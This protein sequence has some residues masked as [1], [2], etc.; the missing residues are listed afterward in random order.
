[1]L[2]NNTIKI[3]NP[4]TRDELVRDDDKLIDSNGNI[5]PIIK[6]VP[7]ISQLNN[8][9][10]NFGMQWNKFDK[11][12]L[13]RETEGLLLSQLR[14]FAESGWDPSELDG[15]NILEVGSGAGRFTKVVLERTKA[16]LFSVDYSD[17][18]TANYSNNGVKYADRLNLY[19]A[20]IYEMP[21]NDNVF[22]KVFCF[23]VLQHT[24]NFQLSIKALL[25]KV[26]IGGEVVVDFYPVKGWWTKIHAKYLFRPLTKKINH[27]KLLKI[28]ENNVGWLIYISK[29]LNKFGLSF[30]TRFIPLVDLK[31]IPTLG[32]NNDQYREW[33]ILDTFDMFSPEYDNPQKIDEVAKMFRLCGAK[34]TFSDFVE[35]SPGCKAAVVRAIKLE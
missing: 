16:N 33:V 4:K 25:S 5:F 3:I 29:L 21:F 23:G 28:I 18:V 34:I 1:M 19:Q 7:R 8:Y 10:N 30:L 12:Q 31:T 32:L 6:G 14:F 11:T 9:T 13:D 20:S 27:V 35:Y 15:T 26:K 17:A 2:N 24:P 22:D